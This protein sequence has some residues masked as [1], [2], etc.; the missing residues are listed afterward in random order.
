MRQPRVIQQAAKDFGTQL[1]FAD[2]FMAIQPR[3]A[4]RLSI[5]AVPYRYVF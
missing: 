3:T 1:P 2:M 4:F 5:V